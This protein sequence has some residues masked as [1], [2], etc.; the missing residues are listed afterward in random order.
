M[1]VGEFFLVSENSDSYSKCAGAS[2][3]T[4]PSLWTMIQ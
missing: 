3:V 2:M 1:E 4:V